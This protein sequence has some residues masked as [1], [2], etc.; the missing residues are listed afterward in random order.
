LATGQ[1][2]KFTQEQLDTLDKFAERNR[3]ANERAEL[4]AGMPR[5]LE[6]GIIYLVLAVLLI[7]FPILYLAKVNVVIEAKGKV[8]PEGDVVSLQSGQGGMVV[9]LSAHAGDRLPAGAALAEIDVS[10]AGLNLAQVTNK[11]ALDEAQVALL[12]KSTA[13]LAAVLADPRLVLAGAAGEPI[14]GAGYQALNTLQNAQLKLDAARREEQVLPDRMREAQQELDLNEQRLALLQKNRSEDQ[15]SLD[16]DTEALTRKKEQLASVRRLG[17][18]K[19]LSQLEVG[20]EEER[21][22]SAENGVA[23]ARQRVAQLDVDISNARLQLSELRSKTRDRENEAHVNSR[24][25]QVQYDQALAT[26]RQERDNEEIQLR[27]LQLEIEQSRARIAVQQRQM[28]LAT[29]RMPVSG[30]VADL[31]LHNAGELVSAG[32]S[33][34]TVV[35]DG[36]PLIVE[37]NLDNKDIGF[38]HP[39]TEA[40]VKVDAFPYQQFGTA[41]ARVTRVLPAVGSNAQFIVVLDLLD[42]QLSAG[43]TVA[44]LIPGLSVQAGLITRQQRIIQTLLT[45]DGAGGK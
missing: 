35:P 44:N 27:G 42:R 37:A 19:L 18:N 36:V 1:L 20:A 2:G 22:R 25:S 6:R 11:L 41:R 7:V 38:V 28:N 39:G 15:A 9:R 17:E 31:K 16:L 23:S 33:V 14:A 13:R 32:A 26:V 10:E 40:R 24:A 34:A 5:T 45:G 29:I 12:Q 30:T 8:L 3:D 21:Y 43:G 4:I